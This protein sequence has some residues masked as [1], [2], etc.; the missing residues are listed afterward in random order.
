MTEPICI[1]P[2]SVTSIVVTVVFWSTELVVFGVLVAIG[3]RDV[4]LWHRSRTRQLWLQRVTTQRRRIVRGLS[5][6]GLI[7][8]VGV[9]VACLLNVITLLSDAETRVEVLRSAWFFSAVGLIPFTAGQ[10]ILCFYRHVSK[11]A[12]PN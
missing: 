8:G 2:P 11:I 4:V 12:T 5:L 7:L 6:I 3:L 9:D 10:S 1:H